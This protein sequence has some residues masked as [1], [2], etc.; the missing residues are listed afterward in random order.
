VLKIA[1]VAHRSLSICERSILLLPA[2]FTGTLRKS[3]FLILKG[4][5]NPGCHRGVWLAKAQSVM[6]G[7]NATS[8][9]KEK[10]APSCIN[11]GAAKATRAIEPK[12]DL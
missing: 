3:R 8:S 11:V 4:L 9:S 7:L 2:L 6:D 5:E 1:K 10:T 12:F